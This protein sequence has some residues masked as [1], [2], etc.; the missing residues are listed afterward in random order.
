MTIDELCLFVR[1]RFAAKPDGRGN[2]TMAA[3]LNAIEPPARHHLSD[4]ATSNAP[5]YA[6][7]RRDCG[8]ADDS[9]IGAELLDECGQEVTP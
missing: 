9:G 5:A 1:Q 2:E 6:P 8:A 7:G 3:T 4:F